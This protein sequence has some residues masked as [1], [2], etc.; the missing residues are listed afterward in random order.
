ME[1]AYTIRLDR[2]SS[3]LKWLFFELY[4]WNGDAYAGLL[5]VMEAQYKLRGRTLLKRDNL[6]V[7][8]PEW[9]KR[10]SMQ[11]KFVEGAYKMETLG[12]SGDFN[13][14]QVFL[15]TVE[16]MLSLNNTGADLL[17]LKGIPGIFVMDGGWQNIQKAHNA[18]RILRMV[19]DIV[20]PGVLLLGE[21]NGGLGDISAF[22][23]R[24]EK[25][26]LHLVEDHLF[27]PALWQTTATHDVR[28]L[29][30]EIA[31]A[32]Q[33]P[34]HYVFLRT[35]DPKEGFAWNLDR[36]FLQDLGLNPEIHIRYL[37]DY[38]TDSRKNP[39]KGKAI[40]DTQGVPGISGSMQDLTGITKAQK[41]GDVAAVRTG[42]QKSELL[43][44]LLMMQSGIPCI[45]MGEIPE[46]EGLYGTSAR[47][48]LRK[49][50]R[51]RREH[52][53]FDA[54]ADVWT[55]QTDNDAVIGMG[56]YKEGEKI[57]GLFNFSDEEQVF[58]LRDPGEYENLVSGKVSR[59]VSLVR[60][61]PYAYGWL[62][63][64]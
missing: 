17:R 9:Y 25:P 16:E 30:N 44:A 2:F 40:P 36:T 19:N 27:R 39:L 50:F 8:N 28:L 43:L 46:E 37:Q 22:F 31:K 18:V 55:V 15:K 57:Y 6:L 34:K 45:P 23:G 60:L 7:N 21:L 13:D 63:R 51:F 49:L 54:D 42:V 47:T 48:L 33:M 14:P 20:S 26:E 53:V 12:L 56:R 3:E 10:A 58:C 32:A 4:P 64:K 61:Q 11:E 1:N 29:G 35:V 24:Y 5:S 41:K 62:V 38:F 52:H 59:I